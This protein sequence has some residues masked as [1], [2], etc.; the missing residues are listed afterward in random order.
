MHNEFSR[1]DSVTVSPRIFPAS[2][3]YFNHPANIN[4]F[5]PNAMLVLHNKPVGCPEDIK[6][7]SLS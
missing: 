3:I 6:L 2:K 5:H 1:I 4:M 7:H